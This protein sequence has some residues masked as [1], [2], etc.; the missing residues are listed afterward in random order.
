M[1]M[2]TTNL[3]PKEGWESMKSI[4]ALLSRLVLI[5]YVG[6]VFNFYFLLL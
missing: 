2:I 4:L 3:L 6:R 5:E 1:D